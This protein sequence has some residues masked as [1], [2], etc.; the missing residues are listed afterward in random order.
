MHFQLL[1]FNSG[2]DL[3]LFNKV[4]YQND[5]ILIFYTCFPNKLIKIYENILIFILFESFFNTFFLERGDSF[6][7]FLFYSTHVFKIIFSFKLNKEFFDSLFLNIF[8]L[9]LAFTIS[10][11]TSTRCFTLLYCLTLPLVSD[12]KEIERLIYKL[13]FNVK[14]YYLPN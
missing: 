2:L 7:I 11:F 5:C 6:L 13:Y 4:K 3:K 12:L 14:F 10:A 8:H 1:L 9:S